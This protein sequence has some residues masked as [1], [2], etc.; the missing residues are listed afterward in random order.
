MN[1]MTKLL[2][3]LAV[4]VLVLVEA[5]NDRRSNSKSLSPVCAV[6]LFVSANRIRCYAVGIMNDSSVD[7]S[8]IGAGDGGGSNSSITIKTPE[9][10][11]SFHALERTAQKSAA[12]IISKLLPRELDPNRYNGGSSSP[13][14]WL[15]TADDDDRDSNSNASDSSQR[16]YLLVVSPPYVYARHATPT[17][18]RVVTFGT[19]DS[20]KGRR[21]RGYD[22]DEDGTSLIP[23]HSDDP[24]SVLRSESGGQSPSQQSSPIALTFRRERSW[25]ITAISFRAPS[26]EQRFS[27]SSPLHRSPPIIDAEC[28]GFEA[29]ITAG[30]ISR[31]CRWWS[32]VVSDW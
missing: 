28:G 30:F 29:R 17:A 6:M 21:S 23:S 32:I 20:G 27:R 10:D 18:L 16:K 1:Q 25:L 4:L 24:P 19:G 26:P 11:R 15:H 22:S 9:M 8:I 14:R 5:P 13:K 12:K 31:R 2:L 7:I 3:V